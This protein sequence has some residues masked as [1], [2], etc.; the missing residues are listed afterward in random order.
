MALLEANKISINFGGLQALKDINLTIQ[1]GQIKAMIGP[2]GAGKTTLFNLINGN[3]RP[4]I[5]SH[6]VIEGDI[7]YKG[8]NLMQKS[9]HE[10]ARLGIGRT[11]QQ[12]VLFPELSV[13]ENVMVGEHQHL[14]SNLFSSML[15]LPFTRREEKKSRE[16]AM[17]L[18]EFMELKVSPYEIAK[19]LP[20]G[21][22]RLVEITRALAIQPTLLLLDEP[23]AG[24][25]LEEQH[26]LVNLIRKIR[27]QNITIFLVEHNMTVA[28]GVADEVSVLNFGELLAEGTPEEIQ[29]NET[30]IE[31]YLGRDDEDA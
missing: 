12:I 22:K 7:Y 20:Y 21:I 5:S 1:D 14:Q 30:V 29:Q 16:R 26:R 13:L 8:V 11:F 23:A 10:V 25:N 9:L 18:I 15:Q 2:N 3:R 4:L 6:T 28:M 31:A 19:N 17:E 27:D 24:M